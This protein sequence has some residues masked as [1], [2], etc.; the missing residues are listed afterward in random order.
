MKGHVQSRLR[1]LLRHGKLEHF[2][3]KGFSFHGAGRGQ[4]EVGGRWPRGLEGV[5][6]ILN[7]DR[8]A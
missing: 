5:L 3:S 6:K 4:Q 7:S 1:E 8:G 2:I